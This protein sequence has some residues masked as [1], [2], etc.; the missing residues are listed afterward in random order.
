MLT[1]LENT[2]NAS[3]VEGVYVTCVYRPRYKGLLNVQY[4]SKLTNNILQQ[5]T[6]FLDS[7][8]QDFSLKKEY[9]Q[10]DNTDDILLAINDLTVEITLLSV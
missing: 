1:D 4:R 5:T 2:F 7:Y 8:R 3:C 9:H 10:F 6:Y